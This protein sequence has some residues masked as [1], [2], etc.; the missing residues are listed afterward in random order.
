MISKNADRVRFKALTAIDAGDYTEA[1][2]HLDVL[3]SSTDRVPDHLWRGIVALRLGKYGDAVT[4]YE[5]ALA[6]EPDNPRVLLALA[7]IRSS[8]PDPLLRDG[9]AALAMAQRASTIGTET[10]WSVASCLAAAYAEIGDFKRARQH[11]QDA[12]EQA[13]TVLKDRFRQRLQ[14]YRDHRPYRM[15]SEGFDGLTQG[16][17]KCL[18]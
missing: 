17:A 12:L 10:N 18:C 7:A 4:S 1:W 5:F 9:R 13:P 2:D 16:E 14:Q 8:S 15:P 11:I 6:R 3:A